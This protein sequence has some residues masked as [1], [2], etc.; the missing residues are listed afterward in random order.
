M[1]VPYFFRLVCL[2][3]ATFFVV[4]A[5]LGLTASLASRAAIRMAESKRPRTAA[6][7]LFAL[8]VFPFALGISTVL[9]L[10]VPSYLWLE[11]QATFERVGW[12][13][14][15]LGF[16]GALGWSLSLVRTARAIAASTCCNR[17][18]QQAGREA[19]LPG[20]TSEALVV[21][22]E[23][24]LMALAGVFRPK[25]IVSNSVLRALSADELEVA[26]QHENA[27]RASRDNM[28]RLLLLMAFA[29]LPAVIKYS[30]L[31]RAWAKYSE[32][33]ADDEAAGGDPIRALSLA[34]A[35][36][37]VARIGVKPHLSL[38]HSSLVASDRE[39]S[40]RVDRLLRIRQAGLV[41]LPRSR[42]RAFGAAFGI[43]AC[44][45]TLMVCPPILS[46]VHRLLE[47]FLR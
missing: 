42:V 21:G 22:E 44:A 40:A 45:A 16:L 19:Q 46:S 14:L 35:L 43:A 13:C 1:N 34:A 5:L 11:P 30:S 38:L 2:C 15:T 41:P 32:W 23:A 17:A 37:R 3:L 8:R 31:D 29:P 4:N 25:L 20:A 6:R 47:L 7:F 12:A 36:L 18:W 33:A 27:H 28:K 39:L 26:L 10:C 9:A 24:P